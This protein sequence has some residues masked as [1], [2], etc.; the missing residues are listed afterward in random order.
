M[1]TVSLCITAVL[2]AGTAAMAATP[3]SNSITI[4]MHAENKSA[5]NGTATLTN[6]AKGVQIAISLKNAP[7]KFDQPTH[8]H[9]GTCDK[10]NPAPEFPLSPTHDGKSVSVYPNATIAQLIAKHVSINVHKSTS[11]LAT[12]VSCGEIK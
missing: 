5:E 8:I 4:P 1:R 7:A 9:A 12:Y 6:T 3:K 10:L 11:D 2:L